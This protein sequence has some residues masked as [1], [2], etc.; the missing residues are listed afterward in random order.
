MSTSG[1]VKTSQS[2]A[3]TSPCS[4]SAANASGQVRRADEAFKPVHLICRA[5]TAVGASGD[6]MAHSRRRRS[7]ACLSRPVTQVTLSQPR[8]R[9]GQRCARSDEQLVLQQQGRARCVL[10]AVRTLVGLQGERERERERYIYIYVCVCVCTKTFTCT[11][12]RKA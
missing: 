6:L 4:R 9:L 1:T 7:F 11:K 10:R 8:G 12:L 2:S 5:V 3:A